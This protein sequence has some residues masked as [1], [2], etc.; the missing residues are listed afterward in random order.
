MTEQITKSPR[1]KPKNLAELLALPHTDQCAGLLRD[2][3]IAVEAKYFEGAAWR[4]A[5]AAA[6]L[7]K[8]IARKGLTDVQGIDSPS[9]MGGQFKFVEGDWL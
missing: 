5:D 3:A 1:F 8:R 9:G 2:A 4:L 6:L 7:S